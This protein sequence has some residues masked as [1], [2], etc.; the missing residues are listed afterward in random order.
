MVTVTAT[1]AIATDEFADMGDGTGAG[2]WEVTAKKKRRSRASTRGGT[3]S[4]T[5][6]DTGTGTGTASSIGSEPTLAAASRKGVPS[7]AV[8]PADSADVGASTAAAAA[9]ATATARGTP[10]VT[11]RDTGSVASTRPPSAVGVNDTAPGGSVAPSPEELLRIEHDRREEQ[12]RINRAW[13]A[14]AEEEKRRADAERGR[15]E[16]DRAQSQRAQQTKHTTMQYVEAERMRAHHPLGKSVQGSGPRRGPSHGQGSVAPHGGSFPALSDYGGV[17]AVV[18]VGG[19]G[20]VGDGGPTAMR[21]PEQGG[22][23]AFGAV[24]RDSPIPQHAQSHAHAHSLP[25]NAAAFAAMPAGPA[26]GQ[27]GPGSSSFG[28][29]PAFGPMPRRAPRQVGGVHPGGGSELHISSRG[30]SGVGGSGSSNNSSSSANMGAGVGAGAGGAHGGHGP[31]SL[32]GLPE[33]MRLALMNMPAFEQA[34]PVSKRNAS[35]SSRT[36][37]YNPL[38]DSPHQ[39]QV[40][41]LAQQQLKMQ[42]HSKAV[43]AQPSGMPSLGRS[44]L[45]GGLLS[46][47][48]QSPEGCSGALQGVLGVQG[49]LEACLSSGDGIDLSAGAYPF[50]PLFDDA[51]AALDLMRPPGMAPGRPGPDRGGHN[52]GAGSKHGSNALGLLASSSIDLTSLSARLSSGVGAPFRGG[53]ESTASHGSESYAV[54]D[55]LDVDVSALA[56]DFLDGGKDEG[57]GSSQY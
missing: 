1:S 25:G 43:S 29:I 36:D 15:Q 2:E 39:Q 42:Q 14:K 35:G 16:R 32:A 41:A 56:L 11:L 50:V 22:M 18:K 47:P 57:G 37:R 40:H 53:G 51:G 54:D 6:T 24:F 38:V 31:E 23:G 48:P 49:A 34:T 19:G 7:L 20:S 13:N 5:G 27:S 3:D 17:G 52:A 12:R 46:P 33:D 10:Y 8:R 45:G 4:G 55:L 9:I 28:S 21:A 26:G 44:S 30:D